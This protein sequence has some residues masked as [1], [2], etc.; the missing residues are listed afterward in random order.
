MVAAAH[1]QEE[2]DHRTINNG[3]TCVRAVTLDLGAGSSRAP[4]PQS[5]ASTGLHE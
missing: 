3:A 1:V 5:P 2:I 4:N